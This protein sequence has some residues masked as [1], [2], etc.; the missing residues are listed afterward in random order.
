MYV[1]LRIIYTI[2]RKNRYWKR[3]DEIAA[4]WFFYGSFCRHTI[5]NQMAISSSLKNR[6]T[7]LINRSVNHTFVHAHG[8]YM[9][10]SSI[11]SSWLA[12]IVKMLVL[13]FFFCTTIIVVDPKLLSKHSRTNTY[14]NVYYTYAHIRIY[15]NL[16]IIVC[17][18]VRD[19]WKPHLYLLE[20]LTNLNSVRFSFCDLYRK[21]ILIFL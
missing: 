1:Y 8:V 3:F 6:P 18:T 13:C 7:V 17:W 14:Y 15:T 10:M 9:R 2:R 11:H 19:N 20:F 4:L 5:H 12:C 21:L 16:N